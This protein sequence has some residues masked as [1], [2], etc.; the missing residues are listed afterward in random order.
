MAFIEESSEEKLSCSLKTEV[1]IRSFSRIIWTSPVCFGDKSWGPMGLKQKKCLN[2]FGE[3]NT[4]STVAF[5][6]EI[7]HLTKLDASRRRPQ[8]SEPILKGSTEIN[9]ER[10]MMNVVHKHQRKKTE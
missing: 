7:F 2:E 5:T 1:S 3:I 4:C 8:T 9:F 10:E 6:T